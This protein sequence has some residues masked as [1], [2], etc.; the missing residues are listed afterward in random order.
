[1]FTTNGITGVNNM[2][3]DTYE[4]AETFQTKEIAEM[5]GVETVTVRKYSHAL[6]QYGYQ[7]NKNKDRRVFKRRDLAVLQQLKY[8]KEKAGMN[9]NMTAEIVVMKNADSESDYPTNDISLQAPES[10]ENGDL[11][12]YDNRMLNRSVSLVIEQNKRI[13]ERLDRERQEN[14]ELKKEVAALREQVDR[15]GK[16]S[17]ERLDT[18]HQRIESVLQEREKKEPFWKKFFR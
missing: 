2:K 8:M 1:M 9:L 14:E 18:F 13:I 7:F 17:G 12:Q 10:Q 5:L 6:E 4:M 11:M 15:Q 16:H 3:S